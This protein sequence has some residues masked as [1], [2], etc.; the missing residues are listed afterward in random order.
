MAFRVLVGIF[1]GIFLVMPIMSGDIDLAQ[2][3][4]ATQN[5][6]EKAIL[7]VEF[8]ASDGNTMTQGVNH[9]L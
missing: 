9:A 1:I 2:I 6:L 3:S 8:I 4:I 7:I 5:V